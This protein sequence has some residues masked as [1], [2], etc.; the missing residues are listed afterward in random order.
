[1]LFLLIC[2][3]MCI[4]L[5]SSQ[6]YNKRCILNRAKQQCSTLYK[7]TSAVLCLVTWLCPILCNPMD[8]SPP[9]STVHGDS[10][11]KNT[12]VGCHNLLQGVFPTQASKSDLLQCR[13]ILYHLSHQGSLRI[14]KW[15]LLLLRRFSHVRLC[16]PIDGSPPGFPSL[17]FSRQEHW[18]G[19][20]FPSP[21]HESEK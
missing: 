5:F 1:M 10:P 15:V 2:F 13:Q 18:S 3:T 14:L 19:L 12:R 8:H 9:D 16:D 20:P 17:G 21:M 4:T 7:D 11:G 6:T